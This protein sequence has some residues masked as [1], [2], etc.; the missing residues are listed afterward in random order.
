MISAKEYKLI[1]D[2]LVSDFLDISYD[3]ACA[4]LLDA[5]GAHDLCDL[6]NFARA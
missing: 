1:Y 4:N 6:I 3:S 2:Y 5:Y